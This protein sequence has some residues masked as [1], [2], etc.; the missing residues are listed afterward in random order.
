MRSQ[1]IISVCMLPVT[2]IAATCTD[3][4]SKA[5]PTVDLDYAVHQAS[6][7]VSIL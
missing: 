1:S 5:L 7:D 3:S 2:V 4:P 6:F